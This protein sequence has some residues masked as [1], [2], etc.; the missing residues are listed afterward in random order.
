[1]KS[2]FPGLTSKINLI[3]CLC[4]PKLPKSL[5]EDPMSQNPP[6][7]KAQLSQEP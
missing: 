5:N 2:P 6:L 1:M 4:K 7:R 3:D